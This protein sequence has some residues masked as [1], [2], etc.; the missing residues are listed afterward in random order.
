MKKAL[1]VLLAVLLTFGSVSA[2]AEATTPDED[3]AAV[4]QAADSGE[5]QL[6]PLQQAA[7][8][9]PRPTEQPSPAPDV[10]EEPEEPAGLEDPA[11]WDDPAYLDEPAEPDAESS[12]A[13]S[14]PAPLARANAIFEYYSIDGSYTDNVGNLY[15]YSYHVPQINADS[16]DAQAI[17]TQLREQFGTQAGWAMEDIARGTSITVYTIGWRAYWNG[18]QV[19][20]LVSADFPNDVIDYFAVGY[21]FEKNCRITKEMLLEQLGIS[22]SDYILNLREKTAAAFEF[23][24]AGPGKN[25][26]YYDIFYRTISDE[27]LNEAMLYLDGS[28]SLVS[29][30]KIYT[31][32]GAGWYYG[33]ITPYAYG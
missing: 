29:V 16:L 22:E 26:V 18:S 23:E 32:A 13:P 2:F 4:G 3:P 33:L 30:V 17:N 28:G 9:K 20:L 24:Y 10:P 19:F 27:N 14:Q 21:D 31:L 15:L 12:A 8:E 5:E 7:M 25:S 11:G 1:A 6:S